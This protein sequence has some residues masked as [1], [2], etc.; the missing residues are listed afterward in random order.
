MRQQFGRLERSGRPRMSLALLGLAVRTKPTEGSRPP[1]GTMPVDRQ[2]PC[3]LVRRAEDGT[4]AAAVEHVSHNDLPP[5]DVLIEVACSSL[6]YKD[7]LACRGHPGVVKSFP[8][9]PGIDAAGT[10]VESSSPELQAGA[11]VLVTG[12]GLGAEVW[13]GFSR[14]VRVPAVWVVPL[15]E[16]LTLR[17]CMTYDKHF[18]D[19]AE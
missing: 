10:V 12:Y 14:Y 11:E 2:F 15:P 1:L 6:N 16:P 13:G 19:D 3:Y 5:G 9:V 17:E 8:H 7:A 4:V 18:D